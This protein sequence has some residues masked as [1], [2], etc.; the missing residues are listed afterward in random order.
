MVWPRYVCYFVGIALL[1]WMLTQL[2]MSFPGS[3][4]LHVFVNP[5]DQIGTSEFSPVELIQP[6]IIAVCGALLAWVAHYCPS[7]RPIAIPFGGVALLFLIR[8]LYYF[9]DRYLVENLWQV[10]VGFAAALIIV[11]TYR[12][13]KRFRIAWARVWPSPGLALVFAGSVILFAFVHLVA[14]E[15]LWMSILG[16]DYRRIVKL[17][18]E[19]FIELIGYLLWLVGTIEYAY[20]ARAIAFRKPQRAAR[21]RREK[22]RH[23]REGRF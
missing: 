4:R 20:Q 12:V 7:Q 9:L 2:E 8:E 15:P 16:D 22:R 10:L 13:R 14:H 11:Y 18:V 3:L 21:R 23:D 19:E 5:G 6:L 17:A 1:T